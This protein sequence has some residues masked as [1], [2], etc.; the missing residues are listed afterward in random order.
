MSI[1]PEQLKF[2]E[3]ISKAISK[4]LALVIAGREQTETRPTV[5]KGTKDGNADGWLLL[6]RRLL[7]R[8]HAKSAEKKAW[9]IMDHLE[10]EARNYIIKKSEPERNDPEKV[11]TLFPVNLELAETR[12]TSNKHLC[13][14]SNKIRRTGCNLWTLLKG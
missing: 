13:C 9:A 14:V 5:N 2:T 8:V 11:F 6:I 4:E 7:E 1:S 10:G 3:A 12:C